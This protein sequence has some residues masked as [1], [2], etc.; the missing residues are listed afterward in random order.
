MLRGR[1][2]QRVTGDDVLGIID[3]RTV[4]TTVSHRL[5]IYPLTLALYPQGAPRS[6]REREHFPGGFGNLLLVAKQSANI[7]ISLWERARVRAKA[8][9]LQ[10]AYIV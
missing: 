3:K 9:V 8:G 1:C 10:T 4:Q 5:V 6:Q 2:Q 7:S